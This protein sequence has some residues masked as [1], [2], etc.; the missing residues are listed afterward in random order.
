M[1]HKICRVVPRVPTPIYRATTGQASPYN[2]YANDLG[3][4]YDV[5]LIDHHIK[6]GRVFEI[7][8]YCQI[9]LV[10]PPL[11]ESWLIN[12]I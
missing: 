9:L 5:R 10:N 12:R 2:N 4:L 3:L 11:Q 7:V 8:N 1:I 6:A